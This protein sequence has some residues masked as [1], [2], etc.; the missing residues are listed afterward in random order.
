MGFCLTNNIS[1]YANVVTSSVESDCGPHSTVTVTT[2]TTVPPSYVTV[3][4]ED[5]SS[6][7]ASLSTWSSMD[8]VEVSWSSELAPISDPHPPLTHTFT[9][10][11]VVPAFT[12][13]K[14]S[15]GSNIIFMSVGPNITVWNYTPTPTQDITIGVT[16]I[17]VSPLS[18]APPAGNASQANG[19]AYATVTTHITRTTTTTIH[20]AFTPNP[21]GWNNTSGRS[22][23]G[24]TAPNAGTGG[25]STAGTAPWFSYGTSVTQLS[26]VSTVTVN[27]TAAPSYSFP[28]LSAYPTLPPQPSYEPLGLPS[29]SSISSPPSP[30]Y[31]F[32]KRQTCTMV[33]ATFSNGDVRSWCNDWDGST[34]S[35]PS[36]YTTTG[37]CFLLDWHASGS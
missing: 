16:Y 18:S 4:V 17:T 36:S 7:S 30:G 28:S 9:N 13:S 20:S 37:E 27:V 25:W 23:F 32:E 6:I 35:Q 12:V 26:T 1:T 15:D 24:A 2:T 31:G 3:V 22:T 29:A 33:S 10:P 19:T 8:S 34:A 21:H 11:V 5:S 14:T